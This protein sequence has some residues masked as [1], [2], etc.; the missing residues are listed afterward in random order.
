LRTGDYYHLVA[1]KRRP[2]RKSA[3]LVRDWLL[4]EMSLLRQ[5]ILRE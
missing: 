1:T 5:Q 3:I 2:L 4:D